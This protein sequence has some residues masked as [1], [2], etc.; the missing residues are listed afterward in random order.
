MSQTRSAIGI[1]GPT[2]RDP[3]F[4]LRVGLS[5]QNDFAGKALPLESLPS[6]V[7]VTNRVAATSSSRAKCSA[8]TG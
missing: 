4:A 6:R 7:V 3:R 5:F 8:F 2:Q 1:D